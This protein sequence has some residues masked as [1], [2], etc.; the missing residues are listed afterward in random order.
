M[1]IN[2]N[3]NS[4]CHKPLQLKFL[5]ETVQLFQ[6]PLEIF[7]FVKPHLFSSDLNLN[8]LL[9]FQNPRQTFLSELSANPIIAST[10]QKLGQW[11]STGFTSMQI[12]PGNHH[13]YVTC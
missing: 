5:S 9:N 12:D 1:W 3:F 8:N 7:T 13:V 11:C 2:L 4:M 10:P 6:P